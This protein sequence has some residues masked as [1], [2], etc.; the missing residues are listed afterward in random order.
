[1]TPN[2][3]PPSLRNTQ[4]VCGIRKKHWIGAG[5]RAMTMGFSRKEAQEDAK[6]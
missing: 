3:H 5:A 4:P 2:P 1:M 6:N